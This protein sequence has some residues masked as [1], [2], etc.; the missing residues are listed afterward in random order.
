MNPPWTF[1]TDVGAGQTSL[2]YE[3]VFGVSFISVFAVTS[4]GVASGP[5]ASGISQV[6][7]PPQPMQWTFEGNTVGDGTATVN[8][9][10]PGPVKLFT[11]GGL[12]NTVRVAASPGGAS[13]DLP[14]VGTG[15]QATFTGLTNG[16][17]YSFTPTTTNACGS[18]TG[19]QS[20]TFTPG[21]APTW[22]RSAPPLT[23]TPGEYVYKFAADGSPAPALSLR[24]A[25]PWLSISPKGLVSGRPPEGTTSFSYSVVASNG[26]GIQ[27]LQRT[28]IVAG[29]FSVSARV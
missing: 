12:P 20:P 23:S 21:V 28:D 13:I 18:S 22:L 6:G 10:W 16:V 7:R 2:S 4:Q 29:P 17:G 25:P 9:Q 3:A 5:F 8:F 14:V 26:V 24:D 19:G 1:T 27:L 15:V 11:T